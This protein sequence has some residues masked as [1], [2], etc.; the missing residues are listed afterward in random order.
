MIVGRGPR[1]TGRFPCPGEEG[2]SRGK[3]RSRGQRR[4]RSRTSWH[5]AKKWRRRRQHGFT[6]GSEA[7]PSDDHGWSTPP[8][9]HGLQRA[10]RHAV[11]AD[12]LRNP[13]LRSAVDAYSEH[14][15]WNLQVGALAT[16]GEGASDRS[17][18]LTTFTPPPYSTARPGARRARPLLARRRPRRAPVSRRVRSRIRPERPRAARARAPAGGA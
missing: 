5:E 18:R 17:T 15:G 10:S 14:V 3:L 16:P 11:F 8:W 12:P 6:R 9:L 13:C 4:R 2:G 1:G 7:K